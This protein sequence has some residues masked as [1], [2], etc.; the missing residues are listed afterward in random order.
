MLIA[1][2]DDPDDSPD[3]DGP[4]DLDDFERADLYGPTVVQEAVRHRYRLRCPVGALPARG[5]E[6]GGH[7]AEAESQGAARL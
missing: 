1:P 4:A 7:P 6:G 5:R 3:L 2:H